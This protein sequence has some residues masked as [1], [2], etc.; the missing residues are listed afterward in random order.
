MVGGP[1]AVLLLIGQ[2]QILDQRTWISLALNVSRILGDSNTFVLLVTA[3]HALRCLQGHICST[4][5]KSMT[6]LRNIG[7]MYEPMMFP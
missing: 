3:L 1:S 2:R 7:A 5:L 6:A 4:S